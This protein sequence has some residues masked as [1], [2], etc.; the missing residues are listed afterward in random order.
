MIIKTICIIKIENKKYVIRRMFL[1]IF[2]FGKKCGNR[3]GKNCYI[4][5]QQIRIINYALNVHCAQTYYYSI[6]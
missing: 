5:D 3:N 4:N 2:F 1:F 6:Y